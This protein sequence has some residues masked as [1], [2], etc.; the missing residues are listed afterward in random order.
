[1]ADFLSQQELEALWN[2]LDEYT[3][4]W[5]QVSAALLTMEDGEG[6]NAADAEME[7]GEVDNAAAG[8]SDDDDDDEMDN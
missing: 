3:A 8:E 5:L 4:E 2:N 6:D 7:D 1:M